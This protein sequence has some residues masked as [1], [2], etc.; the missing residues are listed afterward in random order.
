MDVCETVL[1]GWLVVEVDSKPFFFVVRNNA[2]PKHPFS[3]GKSLSQCFSRKGVTA[4]IPFQ[5]S[6]SR[7]GGMSKTESRHTGYLNCVRLQ[8]GEESPN[9]LAV[10]IL[11]PLNFLMRLYCGREI[12][13][14]LLS[15]RQYPNL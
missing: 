3:N 4:I 1:F 9:I 12:V 15:R 14:S 7:E 8:E 6:A 10:Q 13:S 5:A 11:L 2:S